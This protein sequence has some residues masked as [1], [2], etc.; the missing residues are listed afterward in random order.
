[1]AQGTDRLSRTLE[2]AVRIGGRDVRA[3]SFCNRTPETR[4][5]GLC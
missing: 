3:A 1:M 2:R 4:G 5:G